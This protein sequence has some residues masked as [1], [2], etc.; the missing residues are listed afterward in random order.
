MVRKLRKKVVCFVKAVQVVIYCK[1]LANAA[2]L[3]NEL[4]AEIT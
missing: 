3:C 1:G 4:L 2:A